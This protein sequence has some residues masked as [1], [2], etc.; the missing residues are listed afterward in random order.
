MEIEVFV[1]PSVGLFNQG[2]NTLLAINKKGLLRDHLIRS[3]ARSGPGV[4]ARVVLDRYDLQDL[5]PDY[6][7]ILSSIFMASLR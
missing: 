6:P 7:V 3:Y 5:Y 4:W 2:L 1:F